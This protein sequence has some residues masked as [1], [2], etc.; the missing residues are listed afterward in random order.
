M[1]ESETRKNPNARP[2]Y[3]LTPNERDNYHLCT[4]KTEIIHLTKPF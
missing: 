4:I 1:V 2:G 3:V